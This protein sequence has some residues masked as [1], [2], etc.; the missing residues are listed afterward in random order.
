MRTN[1]FGFYDY[2]LGICLLFQ[3]KDTYEQYDKIVAKTKPDRVVSH[4]VKK[5][6]TLTKDC[7]VI[8]ALAGGY[9]NVEHYAY[10]SDVKPRIH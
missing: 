10:E 1:L 7:G 4:L 6:W 5:S 2:F 8:A 9:R 3:N